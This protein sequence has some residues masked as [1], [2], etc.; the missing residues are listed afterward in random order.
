MGLLDG[1]VA[2]I[3]GSSRGLG[4]AIAQA[5]AQAGAA[6]V[7]AARTQSAVDQ[8]VADLKRQGAQATGL[9]CDVGSLE[10]VQALSDHAI[11]T[12]G[13]FDVW[14][15]NAGVSGMYGPTADI[16]VE[17][18]ERVIDTNINGTYYGSRLALQH[19]LPKHNGKL[20]NL[21]GRGEKGPVKFQNAYASSKAWVRSFTLALAQEY[22]G[23][24][25]GIYVFNPG[26]VDTDLLR[27][28]QA[29]QGYEKKLKPLETVI[30]LWANPPEVPAQK[31]LWLASA[32]TDGKT[33]LYVNVLDR[34]RFIKGI[35]REV[36]RRLTRRPAPDTSLQISVVPSALQPHPVEVDR[37]HK[38]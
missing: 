8:A 5:Y 34:P 31:A 22:T 19:F 36:Q 24:G 38:R 6:V 10:Q 30:R 23:S 20:I 32:A 4:L 7:L 37:E 16:S 15:N 27:Q 1:K 3:T 11:A 14:V 21:V 12:F 26:L 18:F 25:V 2:V 28:L 17:A 13:T 35:A 9:S 33:G 29:V